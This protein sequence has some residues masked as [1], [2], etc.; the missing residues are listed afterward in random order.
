[1]SQTTAPK[2]ISLFM[3][4]PAE[5]II[6]DKPGSTS[7]KSSGCEHVQSGWEGKWNGGIGKV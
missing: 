5:L 4:Q 6:R 1:M 7:T 3:L 2:C